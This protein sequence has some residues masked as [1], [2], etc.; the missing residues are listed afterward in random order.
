MI[1]DIPC[2][3]NC[4]ASWP[5]PRSKV[6]LFGP[7]TPA[8]NF[9]NW[10]SS[11]CSPAWRFVMIRLGVGFQAQELG[12]TAPQPLKI[13]PC[14]HPRRAPAAVP[15][16]HGRPRIFG[17]TASFQIK[18]PS[19]G[20][21]WG[22]FHVCLVLL[23]LGPLCAFSSDPSA[24]LDFGVLTSSGE[25]GRGMRLSRLPAGSFAREGWFPGPFCTYPAG[26]ITGFLILILA[27]GL[28]RPGPEAFG[29][30]GSGRGQGVY[31]GLLET[32]IL[33]CRRRPWAY[34]F[35]AAFISWPWALGLAFAF[36]RLSSRNRGFVQPGP[37]PKGQSPQP[38]ASLIHWDGDFAGDAPSEAALL[39]GEP[40]LVDPGKVS[41][42][43][44]A[45][46]GGRRAP[47]RCWGLHERAAR[48]EGAPQE[49]GA[50]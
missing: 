24:R 21:S 48:P 23:L 39:P 6:S 26:G 43:P 18:T 47:A 30:G 13:P 42:A 28:K 50:E 37:D 49:D 1:W 29:P 32:L 17:A 27:V 36:G 34:G 3:K 10:S 19:Y 12:R 16:Q 22:L 31:P 9:C 11:G 41:R 25:S 15:A 40:E 5:S 20:C 8:W 33:P 4:S 46:G 38:Q 2:R 14:A 7:G 35:L 45:P 44:Q